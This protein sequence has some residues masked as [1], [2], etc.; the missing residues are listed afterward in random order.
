VNT[1]FRN[2]LF[3][4][5][6]VAIVGFAATGVHAA[7][8][9]CPANAPFIC[10]EAIEQ[11]IADALAPFNALISNLQTENQLLQDR[12]DVLEDRVT[13]LEV[14]ESP[15]VS[16]SPT[17]IATHCLL[18]D[19]FCDDF[20]DGISAAWTRAI[21]GTANPPS[22]ESA[23]FRTSNE[24][25]HLGEY[26]ATT[27]TFDLA[28]KYDLGSLQSNTTFE[29]WIYDNGA[30]IQE[31]AITVS[32]NIAQSSNDLLIA[33]IEG[34]RDSLRYSVNEGSF[35]P[36]ME[37]DVLRT[38]GWHLIQIYNDG[39]HNK[40]YFDGIFV[41]ATITQ[42]PFRYISLWANNIA[43]PNPQDYQPGFFDDVRVYIGPP[44]TI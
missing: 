44:S 10:K 13:E 27:N 43:K 22:G 30:D 35:I 31:T 11:I 16:P 36:P 41:Y 20:E 25:P 28:L 38:V 24:H 15:S 14:T 8:D 7:S 21:G 40:V 2:A 12:V 34:P 39:T 3:A 4:L 42:S 33:G 32:T 1:Y 6:A 26:S 19:I 29:A 5:V 9:K 23:E 18:T 37:N 17:P